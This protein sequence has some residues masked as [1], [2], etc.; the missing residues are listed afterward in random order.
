MRKIFLS[1]YQCAMHDV[2]PA[3]TGADPCLHGVRNTY[4]CGGFTWWILLV[5]RRRFSY[6]LLVRSQR[7]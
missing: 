7:M 2:E 3:M 4:A 6:I 5:S 1:F